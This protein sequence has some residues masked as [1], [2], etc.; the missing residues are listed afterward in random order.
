MKFWLVLV[1][2]LIVLLLGGSAAWTA[3][4]SPGLVDLTKPE[5]LTLQNSLVTLRMAQADWSETVRLLEQKYGVDVLG[6]NGTTPTHRLN[7]AQG[8]IEPISRAIAR[9][10]PQELLSPTQ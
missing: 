6:E 8:F 7:V 5:A 2:F 10:V 4:S 1:S 3:W 9:D